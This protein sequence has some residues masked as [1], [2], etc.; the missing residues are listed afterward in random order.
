[1]EP[2]ALKHITLARSMMFRHGITYVCEN[3]PAI[4]SQSQMPMKMSC[5]RNIFCQNCL[6]LWL[7]SANTCP[8]CR[9][10]LFPK[11]NTH[12]HGDGDSDGEEE[13]EE[14]SEPA[15]EHEESDMDVDV[16]DESED[17]GDSEPEDAEDSDVSLYTNSDSDSD[18]DS[19]FSAD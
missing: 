10:Q 17:H 13:E 2:F 8:T 4:F 14:G 3:L 15:S 19:D 9:A 5:C 7:E 18:S 16:E 11:P 1:M 6:A 12:A